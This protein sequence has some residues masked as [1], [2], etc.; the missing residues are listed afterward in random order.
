M[1]DKI[2]SSHLQRRAVLYVRQSSSYQVVHNQESQRLQYA[3]KQRLHSLGWQE[4]EV[5][6]EDLGRSA[7]GGVDRAGFQRMVAAVCLGQVGAVAAREVS[8]FARNSRDWQQLIEVCR[9]VDTLLIDH[10]TVYDS[11]RSNDRLLL[12][13]KG[14]LNEYELDLLRQ[15]SYEARRQMAGRGE[16]VVAAPV[17][18]VRD[19]KH[20][21]VKD[22]DR[23]VQEA[24][25]LMFRKIFELGSL[26]Q[27]LLWFIEEDLTLPIRHQREGGAETDW[28]RPN[29]HMLHRLATNPIYAGAYAFGKRHS[30][31]DVQGGQTR[32]RIRRRPPEHWW[33]LI[34]NR[35]EGYIAWEQFQRVQQM[36]TGNRQ[37]SA[38]SGAAKRGAALLAGLVRCRRC[39]RKMG[40][41][42]TGRNHEAPRYACHRGFLDNGEPK[43]IGFGGGPLDDAVTRDIF[44]LLRPGAL[45][46][47]TE[48]VRQASRQQE[49]LLAALRLDLEAAQY[50]ADRAR[51]QFDAVD[52]LNRLVADELEKRWNAALVRV[53]QIEQRLISEEASRP[54]ATLPTE[55]E[56]AALAHDLPRVWDHPQTDARLK[57][58]IVRTVIHEVLVD[59]DRK[60]G[61]IQAVIH[62]KGGVH[63][64]I[65]AP[66][67]RRG[68]SPL[69]TP[70]EVVQ[71]VRELAK[72]C[73]DELITGL[74]TRNGLRTG[75]GNRWTKEGVTSLRSHHHIP[76]YD[77]RQRAAD[78]WLTLRESAAHVGVCSK[79]LRLAAE[80]G[81]VPGIHPLNDGPW[82]FRRSELD[83]LGIRQRFAEVKA[84]RGGG[85]GHGRDQLTLEFTST[86]RGE[87]V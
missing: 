27:V 40:V 3:M 52:P 13:L 77:E 51:R 75:H 43:C 36:L 80:R 45:A 31:C 55:V 37:T 85:A 71:A 70:V 50:A 68:Y 25:T 79:T 73:T 82:L 58:R 41:R 46:A 7:A 17:G 10:E 56:L 39:G 34:P 66:C 9:I 2:T 15:R 74:L 57:K 33:A 69:H 11:R 35:H 8:R 64:E 22:P 78:G 26:R 16:L 20:G 21:L 47:V 84:R 59:V 12:G 24:I 76:R 62:W 6:D 30:S 87:A 65:T 48:S 53:Q 49:E 67:L 42:Y 32:R 44:E 38:T 54:D 18:Y 61:Q 5:I 19:G 14:S 4:V 23:R 60:A 81:A 83:E 63:T 29:Y 72:I 28:R 86:W 1:S